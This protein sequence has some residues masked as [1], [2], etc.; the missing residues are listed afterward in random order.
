MI[1]K[2]T[3][4]TPSDRISLC[5]KTLPLFYVSPVLGRVRETFCKLESNWGKIE[6]L[7]L[8]KVHGPKK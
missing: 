5:K 3:C 6:S 2:W 8:A 1:S 7:R 4:D